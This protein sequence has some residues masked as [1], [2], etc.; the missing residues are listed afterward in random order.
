MATVALHCSAQRATTTTYLLYSL[1]VSYTLQYCMGGAVNFL[2][3]TSVHRTN[4]ILYIDP[5]LRRSFILTANLNATVHR[6][7]SIATLVY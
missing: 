1:E 7:R 6:E 4:L 2:P 3:S 5:P